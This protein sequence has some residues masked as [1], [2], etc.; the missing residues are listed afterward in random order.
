[1]MSESMSRPPC[2]SRAVTVR[3]RR[4]SRNPSCDRTPAHTGLR[5]SPFVLLIQGKTLCLPDGY[6]R[7]GERLPI[8]SLMRFMCY[9]IFRY[10]DSTCIAEKT[11][12]S[13]SLTMG[14]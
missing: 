14:A 3:S 2:I 9:D 13:G 4:F 1:M 6:F 12:R 11:E 5:A 10:E 8:F 7:G